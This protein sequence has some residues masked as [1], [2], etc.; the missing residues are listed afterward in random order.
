MYGQNSQFSG[1]YNPYVPQPKVDIVRVNGENGA[2]AYQMPPNSNTL[3][4][5]ES[6]P[7]VWLVQTDGAGYKTITPYT[8]TPFKPEPP[9]DVKS[10]ENRIKKL[11]EMVNVKSDA[12]NVEQTTNADTWKLP[13][14]KADDVYY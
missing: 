7:I 14:H 10:L 8:I 6:A 11:E 12:S 3:L 1:I 5:D 9:V 2:K 4:L 13:E